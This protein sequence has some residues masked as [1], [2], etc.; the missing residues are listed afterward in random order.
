MI[1]R[2]R[3]Q[4]EGSPLGL[5]HPRATPFLWAVVVLSSICYWP[6]FL[7]YGINLDDEGTILYQIFRTYLGEVPYVDFH[8]GYTPGI[9]YLNAAVMRAFGPGVIPVRAVLAAVNVLALLFLFLL[10][11]RVAGTLPAAL[12]MLLYVAFVPLHRA[13]FASFNIPY[14]G[15]YVNACW[16]ATA[17]VLLA[18]AEG[19]RQWWLFAA[20][21]L[22]GVSFFFKPNAGLFQLASVA[23]ALLMVEAPGTAPQAA[24]IWWRRS[25]LLGW[26]GLLFSVTAAL[27]V[28]FAQ[29]AGWREIEL[30]L[31]PP[32]ALIAIAAAAP[33]RR[34]KAPA[35]EWESPQVHFGACAVWVGAGFLV[36]TL[37]W[38]GYL[39]HKMGVERV[40]LEV[41]FLGAR[42]EDFYFSLHRALAGRDA[43]V[44]CAAAGAAL[45]GFLI[46]QG[47]IRPWVPVAVF[48]C[49][50]LA[51]A[52]VLSHRA[53]MPEGLQ[54]ALVSRLE[55]L[56]FGIVQVIHWSAVLWVAGAAYR[57]TWLKEPRDR[58]LV[59][60]TITATCMYLRAYPRTDY[61]HLIMAS[62][63]TVM[64]GVVL[65]GK[66]AEM[67]AAPLR[68]G[69]AK[70]LK[71]LLFAPLV[72]AALVR[73]A[74][75]LD[76]LV[77][78][79]R[80]GK[81]IA[82]RP[83]T[84]LGLERAPIHLEAG[85]SRR[86][87]E[88]RAVV[89]Y[90]ESVTAPDEPVFTFPALDIVT[91][92]AG[93]RNPTRHGY[94]F[95]GW[96]G[97]DVEAEVIA[98]LR[99]KRPR[100]VVVLDRPT[101]FFFHAPAYYYMLNDFL[102]ANYVVD[103]EFGG[104]VV[105]R[106]NDLLP[107]GPNTPWKPAPWTEE[108]PLK[109]RAKIA[110]ELSASD[111]AALLRA[112]DRLEGFAIEEAYQ[113]LLDLLES[114]YHSVRDLAVWALRRTRS[115][116]AALAL[117]R[118]VAERRFSEPRA[119]LALRVVEA[120][121]DLRGAPYLAKRLEGASGRELDTALNGLAATASKWHV[122]RFWFGSRQSANEDL[123]PIVDSEL[124]S[125]ALKWLA[126][127]WQDWRLRYFGAVA[128][129]GLP[130]A[131]SQGPLLIALGSGN[132]SI[133]EAAAWT[134][135]DAGVGH[136]PVTPFLPLLRPSDPGAAG[137]ILGVAKR[138][139]ASERADLIE[140]LEAPLIFD[141]TQLAWL[142]GALGYP[143]FEPALLQ[144]AV[145]DDDRVRTAAAWALGTYPDREAKIALEVLSE[146][147]KFRV[148]EMARRS[149]AERP[150]REEITG[151][152]SCIEASG[153]RIR[154][155][156]AIARSDP[157]LP[158]LSRAADAASRDPKSPN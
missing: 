151:V 16:L 108:L 58:A 89:R 61:M 25:H 49:T 137:I 143:E 3:A 21:A 102:R 104:Y 86:F 62:P 27:L 139:G 122:G 22:T 40:L 125:R 149:L 106:R 56:S 11:R 146:D 126:D 133:M 131:H 87:Q 141:K 9:Y 74:P 135:L 53:L 128:T 52:W 39:I 119:V 69:A 121:G 55:D 68:G 43:L 148:R 54:A 136:I 113:P 36:I 81:S 37:P 4:L 130:L 99:I 17:L 10:G 95:P 138:S 85:R 112:A 48:G 38:L 105:L 117:A 59:L 140:A 116:D 44:T 88:L 132:A 153:H 150:Y 110:E 75:A 129:A 71:G 45:G 30:F 31:A 28:L 50:G 47:K 96:P 41:F 120:V 29:A 154:S 33:I 114:P 72:V 97:H 103:R 34:Q 26:W 79:S 142:A 66:V 64:L 147:E 46:C 57:G 144:M 13:E 24:G 19:R 100:V 94:F 98:D 20:G 84:H 6:L 8:I 63:A 118:G 32:L 12:G 73:I 78:I 82:L 77:E 90:L 92:L 115:A 152:G 156:S 155:R 7:A 67:W 70:A 76:A 80:Q 109:I 158:P 65:L 14:P 2:G 134:L 60:V 107:L 15:W 157:S 93:R 83:Q 42:F 111:E 101:L 91:F 18:Y 145:D 127:P 23:I 1:S 5:A 124:A 51:V 35:A 123:E